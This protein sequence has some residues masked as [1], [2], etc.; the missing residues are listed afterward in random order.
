MEIKPLI[1]LLHIL[2]VALGVG[3]A[4]VSDFLFFRSLRD[5]KISPDEFALLQ[6]T[7]RIV[8]VGIVLLVFSGVGLLWLRYVG[9]G[10]LPS[11]GTFYAKMTMVLVIVV[12]GIVF[13]RFAFPILRRAVGHDLSQTPEFYDNLSRLSVI[14]AISIVSWYGS[15]ILGGLRMMVF[16]YSVVMAVYVFVLGGGAFLGYLMIS[17]IIFAPVLSVRKKKRK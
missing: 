16:P 10:T 14:G 15:M 9:V 3:G 5:R 12:N 2:G 1:N 8:M 4:T 13:H 6:A 17:H 7:S 11:S